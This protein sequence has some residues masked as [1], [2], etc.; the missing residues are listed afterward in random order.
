MNMINL[1][2]IKLVAIDL[3]GTLLDDEKRV[4]PRNMD[5]L[6]RL[7]D[8][9]V[10]IAL[11]S[12]RDCASIALKVPLRHPGLYF[13]GSG[14]ALIYEASSGA[15]KWAVYLA[16]K[17]VRSC[18]DFLLEFDQPIFLNSEN[19]YWVD[20][21]NERVK[22]IE[23]RYSLS[24]QP[25]AVD[26]DIQRPIMR[27]S[28]AAPVSIL[29]KASEK[30]QVQIANL[31]QISLASP[32]W[33]DLLPPDAGKGK[34]LKIMQQM[35]GINASQTMAIGDYESDLTLFDQAGYRVAMANAVPSLKAAAN[36]VTSSN[37]QDGVADSLEMMIG[38]S[39]G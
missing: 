6:S 35:Y 8:K 7:L 11:A 17:T 22:M 21:R 28:L 15:I 24:T 38:H 9:G 2:G 3:D 18:I 12:A 30:A 34:L 19:E 31:A 27:V 4:S 13:I 37:N 23:E 36:Y 10:L 1:E 39:G 20:R 32:D 26:C 14:G 33:L 16:K 29:E 25:F 5:T